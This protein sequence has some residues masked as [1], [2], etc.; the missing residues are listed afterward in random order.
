MKKNVITK[1]PEPRYN[2]RFSE[3]FGGDGGH[4]LPDL[5]GAPSGES[6]ITCGTDMTFP[7]ETL[8]LTGEELD[9]ADAALWTEGSF[10]I[11]CP[12]RSDKT[13]MQLIIPEGSERSVTAVWPVKRESVGEPYLIN[14]PTVWWAD[15]ENVDS[16]GAARRV[17][18]F[19]K[20]FSLGG[21]PPTVAVILD[22]GRTETATVVSWSPYDVT[23]EIRSCLSGCRSLSVAVH[24][25]TGGKY[26][27]SECF[28]LGVCEKTTADTD[29]L[30][31][32]TL[33]PP[34]A[35]GNDCPAVSAAIEEAEKLGGA[36]VVF[37]QGEY[38]F[39]QT[40]KITG[41][42]PRGLI[43]KGLGAGKYD[44]ASRLRPSE[45]N[46]RGL[47]G[48]YTS[49]R[50]SD[51][52][53]APNVISVE[54]D[55]V[56]IEDMTVF[57]A[58]GHVG[59]YT[60]KFGYTVVISGNN[61]RIK[62]V[63]M[64][65]A[66]LRD[67][68]T[69]PSASLLCSNQLF[70][71]SGCRD[72]TVTGCE[73]HTKACAIWINFYD[74]D[75]Y[76]QH[77]LF[78]DR[79]QVRNVLI[80]NCGFYGYTYPYV[81][82][83]GRKPTYD[84]GEISRGITAM[85]VDG[86]IVENCRF[87]GVDQK[88]DVVLTRSMYI[89]ITANHMFIA[90]NSMVNVG[91]TPG[92]G[93][94]GNT[95]EQILLH[96]GFHL[97]GVYNVRRSEGQRLTVR[98]DNIA[99]TDENGRQLTSEDTV[100]NAGSRILEGL[101]KGKRGMAYVAGGR[102]VGQ[103]R[104]ID[105]YEETEDEYVFTI[106]EPWRVEPDET[107]IIVE[108]A[109]FRENIIYG[110]TIMKEEPTMSHGYKS[111]GVLVFFDTYSNIIAGNDFRNL[112]FGV[113]LNS[114][115]KCPVTWCTVRD[116][117]FTGIREAYKDAMQGG[118]STR[119]S[120]CFCESVVSNAGETAGWDDYHVWYTVGNV[121]R[122][123]IC[124]DCDT[125]A[126][127]ATNRWHNLRNHG[128][129]KYYGHEK[130]NCMTVIE[131]NGFSGVSQGILVGNPAYWTYIRNNDFSFRFKDGFSCSELN[132]DHDP[133]NFRLIAIRNNSVESDCCHTLNRYADGMSDS[134]SAKEYEIRSNRENVGEI[135]DYIGRHYSERIRLDDI[136][137][138][139]HLSKYYISHTFTR[140]MNRSIGVYIND[141]R[142]QKANDL[143]ANTDISIVKIAETVGFG[144]PTNFSRG[145]R[146]KFGM[147]PTEYRDKNRVKE[148]KGK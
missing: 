113:A 74:G 141:L 119:N 48:R 63:R 39:P 72:I 114:S 31:V 91:S 97:G 62:N 137:A 146:K 14:L 90:H 30:P 26:G 82:P 83:D 87:R 46:H 109:P 94:D 2:A 142:F 103:I 67:L 133:R 121:F 128:L 118:D 27:W 140:N 107:S 73:F 144:D 117:R 66:D 84:E 99:L 112:A 51:V 49:L 132:Y 7:G 145:F 55:N 102:G 147:T 120:T 56:A 23:V 86:M 139:C 69:D 129:E 85:N 104:Q 125:A 37:G 78:E 60:M 95:G 92:T 24:N 71:D 54:T 110:N 108:T 89:P 18:L 21:L 13:K 52:S 43:L 116:N 32:I 93:F 8:S 22:D 41:S 59:G 40:V 45:R 96:G 38:R 106:H 131:R 70:I 100:T 44:F 65:K 64:I 3:L 16:N 42:F 53:V 81:H 1:F 123:N 10:R 20:N 9:G 6:V 130:G 126:E 34:S 25:G 68:N 79:R 138:A 127:V 61:A 17:R 135:V 12:V 80:E 98:R 122:G 124:R 36:A 15:R 88:N 47:S 115:F 111:G 57:G 58:D 76:C 101:K 105:G 35:D 11:L 134:F 29:G 77:V 75:R 136:A 148:K 143:L 33:A 28:G 5:S 4:G 50:F 19:G